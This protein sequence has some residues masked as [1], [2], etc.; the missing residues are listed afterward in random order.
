MGPLVGLVVG[1]VRDRNRADVEASVVR[2]G[3]LRATGVAGTWRVFP[4]E[5]GRVPRGKITDG[6]KHGRLL[7]RQ[8]GGADRG[9]TRKRVQEITSIA[10]TREG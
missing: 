10:S 9:A 8:F 6:P 2:C 5:S 3:R 1:A 4:Y 7:S